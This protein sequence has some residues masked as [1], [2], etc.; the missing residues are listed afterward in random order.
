M[1]RKIPFVKYHGAGND[2]IMID[3][4]DGSIGSLLTTDWI[5]RACHRHFGIGA[6]GMILLQEGREGADF[7]MKYYNSDGWT[8]SFCGNGGRCIAAFAE[9]LEIHSGAC[10]FL[11]T[12][13]LHFAQRDRHGEISLSM[14]DV[15]T[16]EKLDD[17]NFVLDTGSPHLVV[18]T[19]QIEEMEV[20]WKGREIRNSPPFKEHGINVNFVEI[21]APGEIKLRTYERGV[22]DETLACGTGVV[23]SAIASAFSTDSHIHSWIVHAR[24]GDLHVD[25]KHEVGQVFTNVRLTGPAVESFR[26]EIDLPSAP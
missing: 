3:D 1:M 23:A 24:G 21:L 7:F 6:D 4:R 10:E 19:N 8:S 13:G 22:E 14:T 9:A 11:G 20:K 18:F 25:F 26:G 2:F 16:I 5:A 12:D 17:R 15:H